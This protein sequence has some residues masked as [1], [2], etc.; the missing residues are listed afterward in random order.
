MFA[1]VPLKVIARKE[2]NAPII[3]PLTPFHN[4]RERIMPNLVMK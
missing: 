4:S 2:R 3:K 1:V